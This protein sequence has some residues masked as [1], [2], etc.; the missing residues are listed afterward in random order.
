MY[1][2]PTIDHFQSWLSFKKCLYNQLLRKKGTL[3]PV[4]NTFTERLFD[5]DCVWHALLTPSDSYDNQ[6]LSVKGTGLVE[7]MAPTSQ[8][9][10]WAPVPRLS[11]SQLKASQSSDVSQSF[12]IDMSFVS[13][14]SPVHQESLDCPESLVSSELLVRPRKLVRPNK[15]NKMKQMAPFYL[16]KLRN[17]NY[18]VTVFTTE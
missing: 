11:C 2:Q 12:V 18:F 15:S 14:E 10:A 3:K 6:I 5:L 1:L 7:D 4:V 9:P 16:K 17:L 13:L 8:S